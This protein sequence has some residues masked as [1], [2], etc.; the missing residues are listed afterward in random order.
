MAFDQFKEGTPSR[1]GFYNVRTE[2]CRTLIAEWRDYENEGKRWWAYVSS[3]PTVEKTRAPLTGVLGFAKVDDAEV[4]KFLRRERTRAEKIE[5]SVERFRKNQEL[6]ARFKRE[7]PSNRQLQV[8]Q[9]V[10]MGNITE[11]KVAALHDDGQIV[12]LEHRRTE[13]KHGQVIDHGIA[14]ASHPWLNVLPKV[15]PVA[16]GLCKSPVFSTQAHFNTPVSVLVRRMYTEG[17]SDS[18]EYQRKYV[19]TLDD[20]ERFLESV[21]TGR[22]LGSFLFIKEK[23]PNPDVLFDGKQRMNTLLELISSVLPYKGVY[24]HEMEHADRHS[25]LNRSVQFAEL[26]AAVYS[27]A[28]LLE[29]FLEVNAAGVPQ[30][31]EHL[32]TVRAMLEVER[33]KEATS[34]L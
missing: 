18:P 22:H 19:W 13:T 30:T 4:E 5:D 23:H 3:D 24:W 32:A 15:V 26:D 6:Y 34:K 28:D 27:K 1:Q 20:K 16:T 11:A 12:T 21:F 31:E 25:A 2:K 9:D 29:I 17:V 10:V 33:A 7:I 14:F 8:G